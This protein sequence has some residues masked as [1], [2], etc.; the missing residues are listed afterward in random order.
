MVKKLIICIFLFSSYL[1][2]ATILV[3]DFNQGP[4][5]ENSLGILDKFEQVYSISYQYYPHTP[6]NPSFGNAG[7]CIK[8]VHTDANEAYLRILFK[9][10]INLTNYRSLS[11]WI[12]GGSGGE[13]FKMDL[14]GENSGE[15]GYRPDIRSFLTNGITTEWQKVVIPTWTLH[16]DILKGDIDAL[17]LDFNGYPSETLYIDDITFHDTV[18]P[19]YVDTYD[20][21]ADNNAWDQA[22]D[23]WVDGGTGAGL[24]FAYTNNPRFG[25]YG[26]GYKI[27]WT[28]GS[29]TAQ[30]A[31]IRWIM[32]P[33]TGGSDLAGEDVTA[34]NM[35]SFQALAG[36]NGTNKQMAVGLLSDNGPWE[37]R[38]HPNLLTLSNT[39]NQVTC[40]LSGFPVVSL[41]NI[42]EVHLWLNNSDPIKGSVFSNTSSFSF[43]IDNIVFLDTIDP[44]A[45]TALRSDGILVADNYKFYSYNHTLTATAQDGNSDISLEGVF[46]DWSIDNINWTRIG[47]DYETSDTSYSVVWNIRGLDKTKTYYLRSG[48]MDTSGNTASL[49]YQ[50]CMLYYPSDVTFINLT[51]SNYN[52]LESI[53]IKL[54]PVFTNNS[55][56]DVSLFYK[57]KN[58]PGGYNIKKMTLKNGYYVSSL[59]SEDKAT[60]IYYY[61]Q[62]IDFTTNYAFYPEGAPENLCTIDI[63]PPKYADMSI[64]NTLVDFSQG[65]DKTLIKLTLPYYGIVKLQVFSLTGRLVQ[66]LFQESITPGYYVK[67]WD[68]K[69]KNG[70]LVESGTYII[71][72]EAGYDVAVMRKV[73]IVR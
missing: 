28:A 57:K 60:T 2:S 5:R 16:K 58:D 68:C 45:P 67:E 55:L 6:S 49:T 9:Q 32:N 51:S 22:Q 4:D 42:C 12:K 41:T 19:C 44:F 33:K 27:D 72:L 18:A 39:W 34:C 31:M 10:N 64:Y 23:L 61:V 15:P 47:T 3:D 1:Y 59:P 36:T 30:N 66:T 50:N 54:I 65:E 43:Y 40:N 21:G 70:N 20:D 69:D 53:E 35:I 7:Y 25:N 46:F 37:E 11:F 8:I 48:A 24:S 56:L 14:R 62:T 17:I 63:L 13:T 38:F 71:T 29:P 26:Y 73:M 52:I